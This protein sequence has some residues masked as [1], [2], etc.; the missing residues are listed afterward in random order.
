MGEVEGMGG[1][2]VENRLV[3]RL[4]Y[5]GQSKNVVVQLARS[6]LECACEAPLWQESLAGGSVAS[7]PCLIRKAAPRPGWRGTGL[8]STAMLGM[9]SMLSHSPKRCFARALQGASRKVAYH[10]ASHGLNPRMM[11]RD[12]R[13]SGVLL[14]TS[15][16]SRRKMKHTTAWLRAA[17]SVSVMPLMLRTS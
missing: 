7:P 8:I 14:Y 17:E 4:L 12:V 1:S 6:A 3:T 5:R 9:L 15:R 16:N 2:L 11:P 10:E 13:C